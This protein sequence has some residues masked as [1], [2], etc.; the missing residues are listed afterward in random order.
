MSAQ[1]VE[2]PFHP[3]SH[4]RMLTCFSSL[5]LCLFFRPQVI[6]WGFLSQSCLCVLGNSGSL[7]LT[8]GTPCCLL[9]SL[10]PHETELHWA[11]AGGLD[12]FYSGRLS[13]SQ[14]S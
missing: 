7:L 1:P 4:Q 13:V 9:S 6:P 8:P 14:A 5:N 3:M 2:A 12:V 11:G 10:L